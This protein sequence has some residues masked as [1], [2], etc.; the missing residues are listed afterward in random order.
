[1]S[2]VPFIP[3]PHLGQIL[4]W[5]KESDV[6]QTKSTIL[7]S[8]CTPS[9]TGFCYVENDICLA[10]FSL[11]TNKALGIGIVHYIYLCPILEDKNK[12]S[13]KILDYIMQYYTD[14]NIDSFEI[15]TLSTSKEVLEVFKPK[16]VSK[17]LILEKKVKF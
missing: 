2:I 10:H 15:L 4:S 8:C 16:L 12:V 13:I 11:H 9:N 5:W 1:M 6:A 14:Q 3:M 17:S 7:E